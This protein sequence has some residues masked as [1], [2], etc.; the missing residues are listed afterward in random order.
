MRNGGEKMAK[1]KA[2][3]KRTAAAFKR[4]GHVLGPMTRAVL[5]DRA[6]TNDAKVNQQTWAER[7]YTLI[8]EEIIPGAPEEVIVTYGF[9]K[10]KR[11]TEHLGQCWNHPVENQQAVIF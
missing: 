8:R 2:K 10:G 5:A 9:P 4:N 3:G 11:G 1:A 6:E 7:A